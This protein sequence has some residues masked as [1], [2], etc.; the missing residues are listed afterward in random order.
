[1]SKGPLRTNVVLETT[2]YRIR[3]EVT[4]R[5]D[6]RLSDYANEPTRHFFAITDAHIAPVENPER[7]RAVPFL[8]VARH[9]VGLMLPAED[10]ERSHADD[11]A[12]EEAS[13]HFW[14]LME[15]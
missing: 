13:A 8:L 1:M 14:A 4:V 12:R 10:H 7:E 2:R 3:G 6:G 11:H 15:R 5:T 9:E